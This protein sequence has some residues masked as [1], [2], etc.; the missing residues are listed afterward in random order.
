M[1]LVVF[2]GHLMGTYWDSMLL[3]PAQCGNI[4]GHPEDKSIV[5]QR[6]VEQVLQTF[7]STGVQIPKASPKA[8][9][10]GILE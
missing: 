4:M 5:W 7:L 8:I 3:N 2:H 1:D 9:S 6:C 10:E